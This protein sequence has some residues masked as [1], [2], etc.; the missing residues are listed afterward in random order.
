MRRSIS[1]HRQLLLRRLKSRRR[2]GLRS[3]NEIGL[4][5]FYRIPPIKKSSCCQEELM[6]SNRLPIAYRTFEASR[7]EIS[8]KPCSLDSISCSTGVLN[9]GWQFMPTAAAAP[10]QI[11][12]GGGVQRRRGSNL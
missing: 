7:R 11:S 1:L 2:F 6:R 12:D 3:N 8:S 10:T 9:L 4:F 5:L